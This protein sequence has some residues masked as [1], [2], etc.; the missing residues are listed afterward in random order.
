MGGEEHC[1]AGAGDGDWLMQHLL[2]MGVRDTKPRRMV[3]D[4]VSRREGGF[5]MKDA[6]DA[7]E[8]AGLSRPSVY[9]NI[10]FLESQGLLRGTTTATGERLRFAVRPDHSHKLICDGCGVVEEFNSCGW[11]VLGELLKLRTGFA[12]TSH[13]MEVHGLCESCQKKQ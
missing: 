6:L 1:D 13:H 3:C 11:S 2:G 7:L 12:I 4:W 10:A 5:T 8:A 9:R